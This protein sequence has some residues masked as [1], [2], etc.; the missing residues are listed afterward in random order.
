MTSE[1]CGILDDLYP[2]ELALRLIPLC[3]ANQ[4]HQHG[5][6][7]CES[8]GKTPVERNWIKNA[9]SRCWEGHSREQRLAEMADHLD[10]GG[11]VGLVLP[12]G[13]MALDADSNQSRAY[14]AVALPDAPQQET[15]RGGHFLVR[16]PKSAGVKNTVKVDIG[17][18]IQVDI[19][20]YGAQIVVEPS[21]HA[22]GHQYAWK[23]GL[24]A[25]FSDLPEIPARILGSLILKARSEPA[26][27]AHEGSGHHVPEGERN[28]RLT[29]TAGRIRRHGA[30]NDQI[31]ERLLETNAKVCSPPLNETEV[32]EIACSVSGYPPAVGQESAVSLTEFENARRLVAHHGDDL[33]YCANSSEWYVW[34]DKR[35]AL[36][37]SRERDRRAKETIRSILF[38][39]GNSPDEAKRKALGNFAVKCH[40]EKAVRAM[41]ELAKTEPE[42]I[43]HTRQFDCAPNL[44]NVENGTLDLTTFELNPHRRE[45][46]LTNLAPVTFDPSIRSEIWD[47]FLKD[48]LPDP[49]IRSFLRKVAGYALQGNADR[50][51]VFIIHGPPRTGKGSFQGAVAAMLGPDYV[52]TIGLTDLGQRKHQ[53]SGPRPELVRLRGAR[54]VN[55]HETSSHFRLSASLLKTLTG[56]DTISARGLHQAP[57]EFR[58]EFALIIA[59]NFRPQLPDDDDAIWERVWEIPFTHRLDKAQRDHK[60]R[61]R[62]QS[63]PKIRSAILNWALDGLRA[64]REEDFSPPEAV[65]LA[66]RAYREEMDPVQDFLADRCRVEPEKG[67]LLVTA[68]NLRQAY[69]S[70]CNENGRSPISAKAMGPRL[71]GRGCKREKATVAGKR[72]W[73]WRGIGLVRDDESGP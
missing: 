30:S 33:R 47:S 12:E 26:P 63:D 71:K 45:D 39:A 53:D 56:G 6:R 52:K 29:Q 11:N 65:R 4:K 21:I 54:L 25:S 48:T 35:W 1:T 50:D 28:N 9:D 27:A 66:T 59:S 57:I 7:A 41:L 43:M 68:F 2:G 42:I 73:I 72:Q 31:A 19:R 13:V 17:D 64:L 67:A 24:P 60:L 55:A 58:A 62:L 37:E 16:V 61:E 49:E 38:E 46:L 18:G 10:G 15:S 70:W 44:L 34:D 3:P 5:A 51:V 69:E 23:Q 40:S 14:L 32:R 20:G 8:R 22:S 36:D